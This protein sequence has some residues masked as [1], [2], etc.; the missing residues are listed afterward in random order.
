MTTPLTGRLPIPGGL[1]LTLKI[2]YSG[3]DSQIVLG[4]FGGDTGPS[5]SIAAKWR[6]HAWQAFMP[7]IAGSAICQGA[8]LRDASQPDGLVFEVSGPTSPNGGGGAGGN[9]LA[10][11]TLVK[12]STV[13]GG[14]SGKGRTF[15]PALPSGALGTDGRTYASTHGPK[16]A[17]AVAAYLNTT[18]VQAV[19]VAPAVLSYRQGEASVIVGGSLAPV[20]GLQRRRMR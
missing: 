2:S 12:W 15:L 6:D 13:R 17:T 8:V 11:A 7:L 3:Q 5:A 16:V 10:A 14:R 19:G 1:S 4:G 20:I 9:I 18:A